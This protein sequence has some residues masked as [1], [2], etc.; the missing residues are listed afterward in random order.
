MPDVLFQDSKNYC[1]DNGLQLSELLRHLL[2]IEIYNESSLIQK[3][4]VID[5]VYNRR[6]KIKIKDAKEWRNKVVGLA[7]DSNLVSQTETPRET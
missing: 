2:R 3:I 4:E 5:P 1:K 7:K 6:Y